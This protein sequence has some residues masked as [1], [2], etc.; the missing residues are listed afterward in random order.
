MGGDEY[1]CLA[2]THAVPLLSAPQA[3]ARRRPPPVAAASPGREKW[4]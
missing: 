3:L 4:I 1:P 2:P